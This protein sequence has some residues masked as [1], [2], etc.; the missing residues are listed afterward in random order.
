MDKQSFKNSLVFLESSSEGFIKNLSK[1]RKMKEETIKKAYDRLKEFMEFSPNFESFEGLF[2]DN[3]KDDKKAIK[4][5]LEVV[6][7]LLKSEG[8]RYNELL[9][10]ADKQTKD[11]LKNWL[12]DSLKRA[13]DDKKTKR[14]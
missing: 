1:S 7:Y 9:S 3:V 11:N 14:L 13:R 10:L 6:F 4:V 5:L 8:D 2:N 12:N